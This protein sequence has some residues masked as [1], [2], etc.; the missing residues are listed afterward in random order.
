MVRISHLNVFRQQE[1]NAARFQWNRGLR[2]EVPLVG[3]LV[4]EYKRG[5]FQTGAV[6]ICSTPNSV[7]GAFFILGIMWND[8]NPT[9]AILV[10]GARSDASEY[11]FCVVLQEAD[12]YLDRSGAV[13]LYSHHNTEI[14]LGIVKPHGPGISRSQHLIKK[15]DSVGYTF[16]EA[17]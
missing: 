6:V 17:R 7:R 12:D 9:E 13:H 14:Q 15:D 5:S 1:E 11:G 4:G 2:E 3:G 10:M 16:P 8:D